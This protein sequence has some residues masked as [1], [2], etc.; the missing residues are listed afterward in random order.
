MAKQ[1]ASSQKQANDKQAPT[2]KQAS[3]TKREISKQ[4]DLAKKAAVTKKYSIV[5]HDGKK[6]ALLREIYEPIF[7]LAFGASSFDRHSDSDDSVGRRIHKG[8]KKV[9]LPKT[10]AKNLKDDK[11]YETGD[12]W[13]RFLL[14]EVGEHYYAF[15]MGNEPDSFGIYA[16]MT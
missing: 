4:A 5:K 13:D 10:G 16:N 3:I 14:T 2:F 6:R 7:G 9:P 12:P 11:K 15:S 8:S 1:A